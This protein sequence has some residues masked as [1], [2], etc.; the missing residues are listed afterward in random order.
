MS[1][2]EMRFVLVIGEND[3]GP[4]QTKQAASE[5]SDAACHDFHEPKC[6]AASA[7]ARPVVFNG[8]RSCTS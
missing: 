5:I 8:M 6:Y 3:D 4:L 1:R 7:G 2:S